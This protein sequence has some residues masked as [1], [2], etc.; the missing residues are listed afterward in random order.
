MFPEMFD[1]NPVLNLMHFFLIF[2]KQFFLM[3][4]NMNP[5][6]YLCDKRRGEK[7]RGKYIVNTIKFFEEKAD[8]TWGG[9]ILFSGGEYPT[10][11][12]SWGERL[13][14]REYKTPN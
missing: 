3:S 6:T 14:K 2:Q 1:D 7:G 9:E 11:L 13:L 4:G 8:C 5:P 12:D 10:C